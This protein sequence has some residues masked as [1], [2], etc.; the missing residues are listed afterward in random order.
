METVT[1]MSAG[2]D[3]RERQRILAKRALRTLFDHGIRVAIPAGK[4]IIGGETHV[5]R[6][7]LRVR[8]FRWDSRSRYWITSNKIDLYELL[9]ALMTELLNNEASRPRYTR[10]D[11]ASL[12][13]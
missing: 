5:I 12:I 1:T 11:I 6:E 3:D 13:R 7:L 8:G 2:C 9:P 4:M 10:R